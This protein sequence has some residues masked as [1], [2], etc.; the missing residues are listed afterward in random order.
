MRIA[1]HSVLTD[2]T[3]VRRLLSN[4]I[5]I[6]SKDLLSVIQTHERFIGLGEVIDLADWLESPT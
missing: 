3:S 1:C 5:L 6:H 2:V 4:R